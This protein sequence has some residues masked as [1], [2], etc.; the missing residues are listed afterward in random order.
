MIDPL[1]RSRDDGVDRSPS[2]LVS[3]GDV[4]ALMLTF[5]VMLFSMSHLKSEKWDDIISLINTSLKPKEIKQPLPASELNV[6]TIDVLGGL[7][8][9]YL[10]RVLTEKLER[11]PILRQSTVTP[12]QEQVVVS[13]PSDL[14]FQPDG[15]ALVSG[16]EE[17]L[18]RLSGVMGQI[19][20]HVDIVGHTDPT[21]IRNQAFRSNWELSLAR[22]LRV[23]DVVRKSG[24]QGSFS[25]VGMGDS[26]YRHLNE[27]F[28][29]DE[30]YALARRID[31]V[32][33][34]EAGGQ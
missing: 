26:R 25:A 16:A 31:V 27:E 29:E 4:T 3:F 6:S 5:F 21:P 11:D 24:Y 28:S 12:L 7:S 23:A 10:S 15:A 19:G 18:L 13:V 22:A 30:R 9:D 14:L 1:A 34:A 8:T 20:N 32:F 2:W 17:A 33:R